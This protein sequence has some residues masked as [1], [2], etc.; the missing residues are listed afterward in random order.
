M[1]HSQRP[2]SHA[3]V[4]ALLPTCAGTDVIKADV[5]MYR[6]TN[7]DW[8]KWTELAV[9]FDA[10]A[11]FSSRIASKGLLQR[12]SF[13]D[14]DM[15]PIGFVTAPGDANRAPD[16]WSH[17]THDE[18][19]LQV[20]LWAMARSPLFFGGSVTALRDTSNAEAVFTLSLLTN[21]AVLEV[22]AA[23][24]RNREVARDSASSLR[25]WSAKLDQ[26][27][28]RFAVA[29]FN[30]GET[31][32]VTGSVTAGEAGLWSGSEEE[33]KVEDAWSGKGLGKVSLS[34]SA[35]MLTVQGGVPTHGTRLVLV[36]C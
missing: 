16:H 27:R 28:R 8:D 36:E 7:D 33:C 6:I 11:A 32:S 10:A 1:R 31:A 26:G 23:S 15:L 12:P 20:T 18:Q 35:S 9:H 17:L 30:V 29:F 34:G 24:T 14:L 2:C 21:K 22:N 3:A 25:V 5:N 13:P 4:A 19:R